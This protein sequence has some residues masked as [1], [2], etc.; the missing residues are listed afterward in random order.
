MIVTVEF[1]P[2][3]VNVELGT[4][5]I[6]TGFGYPIAREAVEREPYEGAYTVTPGAAAVV[7]ETRNKRMTDNVVVEPIPSN[8]GLITW[9]G[10]IITVS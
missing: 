9:D 10:S 7:L 1:A 8:Y 5:R 4:P 2:T 6:D 3:S